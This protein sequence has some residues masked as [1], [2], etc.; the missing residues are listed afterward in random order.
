[1]GYEGSQCENTL[2]ELQALAFRFDIPFL[3]SKQLPIPEKELA[4]TVI[5]FL[6][7]INH[8]GQPIH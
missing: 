3:D 4:A 6:K 1:M 2:A 7:D 8:D 5:D